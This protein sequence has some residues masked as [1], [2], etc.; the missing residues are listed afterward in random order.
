MGAYPTNSCTT[1][2]GKLFDA[3][4]KIPHDEVS[5]EQYRA[6]PCKG[7]SGCLALLCMIIHL[8]CCWHVCTLSRHSTV[9]RLAPTCHS[10]CPGLEL[11]SSFDQARPTTERCALLQAVSFLRQHLLLGVVR[12]RDS[13]SGKKLAQ[14]S[15]QKL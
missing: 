6:A 12:E 4:I 5:A 10:V 11:M 13:P 1:C 3:S 9:L 7:I 14:G 8:S 15:R 2:T